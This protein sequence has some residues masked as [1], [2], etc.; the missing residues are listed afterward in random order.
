MINVDKAWDILAEKAKELGLKVDL[1]ASEKSDS[2]YLVIQKPYHIDP[3]YGVMENIE[4][5]IR[6]SNH[7]N[8]CRGNYGNAHSYINIQEEYGIKNALL[9]IEDFSKIDVIVS[10]DEIEPWDEEQNYYDYS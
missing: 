7:F 1:G 4:M 6:I 5:V 8:D 2:M 10:E 9:D 3:N